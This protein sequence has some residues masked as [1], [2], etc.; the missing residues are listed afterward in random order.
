MLRLLDTSCHVVGSIAPAKWSTRATRI[1]RVKLLPVQDLMTTDGFGDFHSR[2]PIAVLRGAR[3]AARIPPIQG[4]DQMNLPGSRNEAATAS[5]VSSHAI[6]RPLLLEIPE[7]D[8]QRRDN[9]FAQGRPVVRSPEK[10]R[11]H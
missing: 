11:L 2:R 3:S 8:W 6:N 5:G 9:P 4:A 10:L 7:L 1:A